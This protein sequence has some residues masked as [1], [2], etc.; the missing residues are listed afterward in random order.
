[1]RDGADQERA[2]D[3]R[4][5][6][7]GW[8]A[9]TAAPSS[10]PKRKSPIGDLAEEADRLLS[11]ERTIPVVVSTEISAASMSRPLMTSSPQRRRAARRRGASARRLRDR[12]RAVLP[13]SSRCAERGLGLVG[14]GGRHRHDLRRL[15]DR[16]VVLDHVVHERLDLGLLQRLVARVHEQ[17]ARERL[18]ARR[19]GSCRVLGLTQPVAVVDADEVQ[20]VLVL[21][22]VGEAEVAEAAGLALRRPGRA[23]CRP[24]TAGSRC[25]R[26]PPHR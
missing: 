17:R 2:A 4:Q 6:A 7:E 5:H 1:M 25:A 12:C 9:R 18:V 3:E 16:L 20:L 10:V 11:S 24:R 21:L 15:G 23:R 14:L 19:S 13:P 8:R 22:V 26:R